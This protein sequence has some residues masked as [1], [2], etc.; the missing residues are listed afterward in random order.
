MRKLL[1]AFWGI[2]KAIVTTLAY[3]SLWLYGSEARWKDLWNQSFPPA[4]PTQRDLTKA[5]DLD[6]LLSAA[7]DTLKAAEDRNSA[8][9]DKCKTLLTVSSFL[10]AVV[11]ILLP[12][13]LNFGSHWIQIAFFVAALALFNAVMLLLEFFSVRA[14]MVVT[15][16]Q[17]DI[18]LDSDLLK[19][20]LIKAYFDVQ[21]DLDS[22][23]NYLVEIY[24]AARFS[25]LTAFTVV[26]LL[27]ALT[28]FGRPPEEQA[29]LVAQQLRKDSEFLAAARGRQGEPGLKG[30][31]GPK[32]EIGPKGDQGPRGDHGENC[33]INA[34]DLVERVLRHPRFREAI[35][36]D[37]R[38]P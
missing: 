19:R 9:T 11:G 7:K 33:Y 23:T 2:R 31:I 13:N 29:R 38:R 36:R 24:K 28:L 12:K 1:D 16:D 4:E 25:F 37:A 15:H 22:R 6:L 8:I 35:A 18:E 17:S 21:S 30:D 14:G 34:D 27:F 10:V 20:S 26:I 32:G 5:K 3:I